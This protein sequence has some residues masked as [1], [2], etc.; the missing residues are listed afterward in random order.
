MWRLE[1]D[2]AIVAEGRRNNQP[3]YYGNAGNS[4]VLAAAGIAHAEA[5]V[6]TLD[7]HKAAEVLITVLHQRWPDL[8]IYARARD[9]ANSEQLERLGATE[10]V[11]ETIEASLRLGARVLKSIG[12]PREQIQQQL[13]M[14]SADDYRVLREHVQAVELDGQPEDKK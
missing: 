13:E 12:V 10:A 7:Q 14:M 5:A 1:L 3:V 8:P 6:I 11:P 4:H 2:R 9:L